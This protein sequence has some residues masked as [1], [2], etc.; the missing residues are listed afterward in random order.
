LA[1]V[2]VSSIVALVRC[3]RRLDAYLSHLENSVV[4]EMTIGIGTAIAG[5][6]AIAFSLSLFAI[7]QVSDRGTP[8]T[9]QAYARDR[10]LSLIY[11][12]LAVLATLCFAAALFKPETGNRAVPVI[13]GLSSLFLSFVLLRFHFKRVVRFADPRYTV[14]R[15]FRQGQR[16]LKWLKKIRDSIVPDSD[17]VLR[18]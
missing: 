15:I 5:I 6:I 12:I 10:V 11:W 2:G 16:Q 3:W 7:Q 17:V 8:A 14:S 1:V 4:S 9:V 13:V 18:K